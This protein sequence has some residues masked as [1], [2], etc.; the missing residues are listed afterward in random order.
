MAE[1]EEAEAAAAVVAA[2]VVVVAVAAVVMLREVMVLHFGGSPLTH[3]PSCIS[4]VQGRV[5]RPSSSQAGLEA[6]VG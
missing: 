4:L 5:K 6:A 2:A 1:A 3:L